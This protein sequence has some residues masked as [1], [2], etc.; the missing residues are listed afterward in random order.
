[1]TNVKEFVRSL[2]PK[3]VLSAYHFILATL[4]ALRFRFPAKKLVIIGVTGTKG[5]STTAEIVCELLRGAGA[6]PALLS[7]IR[8]AT[9][10]GSRPNLF[11]MTLP[12]RFFL[13][14]FL[15]EALAASATHAVI[16]LTSEGAVQWR[17]A[18][19]SLDALVFT[20]LAPEHIESHGSLEKYAQA[21]LRLARA[22][23]HSPKKR[24][25]IVANADDAYGKIFLETAVEVHA[26]FSLKDAEPHSSDERGSRFMWRGELFTTPLPGLFN[27]YNALAALTLLEALGFPREKLRKA[28][29]DTALVPGRAERIDC[30]QS[31]TAVVDYAHTSDSLRAIYEAFS[32]RTAEPYGKRGRRICVLGNT[33]G[34]RDRW[35]RPAMGAIAEEYCNLAILANED[36]YDEDPRAILDEM[37]EGFA[38]KKP[39]IIL[40]R[41]EAIR[42][43]LAEAK[44]GDVV[45][46]TGKGTDPYI[47]GPRG[48]KEPWS[49]K[50]VVEEEL[51]KLLEK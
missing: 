28:L 29:A 46:I 2:T 27:L 48:S 1:M 40:D 26:P 18:W 42:A 44:E 21:K 6:K 3:G 11:K 38:K 14:R 4:A 5:K 43:A 16:E 34:G 15:D 49:D 10:A 9:P 32:P 19:L 22:L 7:T 31:F 36:P 45:L 50:R 13:Q 37:A 17:H 23:E 24:R 25:I 8:F 20:N 51:E 12:G 30:G 41:R 47:M 35:K 39:R 33:G